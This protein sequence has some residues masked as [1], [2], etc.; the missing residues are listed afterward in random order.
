MATY[1][2]ERVGMCRFPKLAQPDFAVLTSVTDP[3]IFSPRDFTLKT[4]HADEVGIDR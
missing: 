4:V 1:L 3:G 2:F